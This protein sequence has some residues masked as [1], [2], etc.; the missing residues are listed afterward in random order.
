MDN[1]EARR[2]ASRWEADWNSGDLDRIL[3]LYADDVV[4]ESPNIA[5]WFGDPTGEVRGKQALREYWSAGLARRPGLQFSVVEVR[6][7]VG[8]IVLDYVTEPGG[9]RVA[10]V[11]KLRDGLVVSGCGCYPI[12]EAGSA[13]APRSEPEGEEPAQ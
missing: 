13:A 10:E 4:F 11:L 12:A 5:Q 3:A 7:A 8:T 2:F 9:P 1:D 6:V